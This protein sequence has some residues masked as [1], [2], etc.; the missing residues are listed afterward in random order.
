MY[1]SS[2]V[3]DQTEGQESP[4][5][6]A[7]A[8]SDHGAQ[9]A[10]TTRKRRKPGISDAFFDEAKPHSIVKSNIAEKYF[11]AW[12]RIMKSNARE[13]R[14][15]YIDLYAGRG[16]YKDGTDS[17]P[18]RILKDAIADAEIAEKLLSI[19]A[20]KDAE[21][22]DALRE[23]IN[24]LDG[25]ESLKYQPEFHVGGADEHGLA[26]KF[27]TT[28]IVPTFMFLDPFGYQGLSTK[29]MRAILKDFGCELLFFFS[30]TRI[31]AA[32]RNKLVRE[33]M[34]AIFGHERVEALAE[35]VRSV[36]KQD[37]K[38]REILA[39][40]EGAL[41]EIGAKYV[42]PFRFLN[43]NGHV[44]HHLVFVTKHELAYDIMKG[45]MGGESSG[46]R[47][48]VPTFQF[49]SNDLPHAPAMLPMF[50]DGNDPI[51]KLKADLL[52]HFRGRTATIS[53]I[54][55]EHTYGTPYLKKN[56]QE[57]LCELFWDEGKVS[58]VRAALHPALKRGRFPMPFENTII[59]FDKV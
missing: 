14:I 38:E 31:R 56:Y 17:T 9:P 50:D 54:Y 36:S 53:E 52:E 44:T 6:L 49:R 59:T 40:L 8:E 29:L 19:F 22:I 25:V 2:R 16:Q 13:K 41:Q 18:L 27:A 3:L 28:R 15:A 48:N 58:A 46:Q 57:A 10:Q 33:E 39:S 4:R 30:Y 24:A 7:V 35:V 51:A 55:R 42:L 47:R 26:E 12:A 23:N 21:C 1:D 11:L 45:I 37:D 20:D 43:D 5:H 34:D 32:V